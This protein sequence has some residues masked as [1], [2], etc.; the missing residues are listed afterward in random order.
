MAPADE[1]IAARAAALA[2]VAE[3]AVETSLLPLIRRLDVS[4]AGILRG[5]LS[6]P[7]NKDGA[8]LPL[9]PGSRPPRASVSGRPPGSYGA[10]F[11]KLVFQHLVVFSLLGGKSGRRWALF[12]RR[13]F[14]PTA[15]KARGT[16]VAGK[17]GPRMDNIM[18]VLI[19]A[20][21]KPNVIAIRS[22]AGP[23]RLRPNLAC[24]LVSGGA[25][26]SQPSCPRSSG[27]GTKATGPNLCNGVEA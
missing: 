9:P 1:T 3:G 16:F 5:R 15:P 10:R 7:R 27:A 23:L 21:A 25:R 4:R 24:K 12:G 26:S 6:L 8:Y 20:S 14:R 17:L 22:K 11:V 2:K 18:L 13:L 19:E